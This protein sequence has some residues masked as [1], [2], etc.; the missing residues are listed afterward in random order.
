MPIETRLAASSFNMPLAVTA[1]CRFRQD[2]GFVKV[3]HILHINISDTER[4]RKMPKDGWRS[5]FLA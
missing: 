4:I 3:N 1:V 5:S 2:L